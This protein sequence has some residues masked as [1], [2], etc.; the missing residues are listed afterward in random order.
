M[1][2]T[3]H[4]TES[5]Y[6]RYDIVDEADLTAGLASPR[7]LQVTPVGKPPPMAVRLAK[8]RPW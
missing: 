4:Q 5:V 7:S 3:G 8:V 6:R 1:Q 2:I